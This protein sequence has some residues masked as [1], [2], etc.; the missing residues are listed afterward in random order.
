MVYSSK[1]FTKKTKGRTMAKIDIVDEVKTILSQETDFL[2]PLVK[3]LL[4][5]LLEAEMVE[6]IG[7]ASYQRCSERKGYRAGYY[8]RNYVTRIVA[9]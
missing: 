2:K 1:L 4:N 6:M 7:A 5:E 3:N 8:T 9:P